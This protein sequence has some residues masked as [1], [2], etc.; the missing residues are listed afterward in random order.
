MNWQLKSRVQRAIGAL[1]T[2]LADPLYY[3]LQRRFG[4]FRAIDPLEHFGAAA[5]MIEA[6]EEAGGSVNSASIFELGTGHRLNVPIALWLRGAASIVTVDLN[7]YLTPALVD[8]DLAFARRKPERVR[9]VLRNSSASPLDEVR[10]VQVLDPDTIEAIFV[11]AKR[12]VK[13][14]GLLIHFV[15]FS[16]HFSHTDPSVSSINFLQFSAEEWDRLAGNRYMYHNRLR[17]DDYVALFEQLGLT[18]VSNAARVDERALMLLREGFPLHGSYRAKTPETLA[19]HA[20]IF[21]L[22]LKSEPPH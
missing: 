3:V 1:P 15:D 21:V 16:D 14:G 7:R 5:D 6:V 9:D 8:Q 18:V 10:L 4:A 22:S 12:I 19:T 17:I 20:S 11:E 13:P 2:R